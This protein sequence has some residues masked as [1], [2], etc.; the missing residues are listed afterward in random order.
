MLVETPVE[1]IAKHD[2]KLAH[3][4]EMIRRDMVKIRLGYDGVYGEVEGFYSQNSL[5]G[6]LNR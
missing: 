6:L 2:K 1:E 5:A 3:A 4:V